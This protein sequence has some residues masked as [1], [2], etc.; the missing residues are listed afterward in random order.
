[1]YWGFYIM[2]NSVKKI[3]A[4]D[5][6]KLFND[7]KACILDV[8]E[9]DEHHREHIQGSELNPLS[10]L[11]LQLKDTKQYLISCQSGM[12][13]AQAANKFAEANPNC[14]IQIIDGGIVEWKKQ[15]LPVNRVAG[16]TISIMRQVQII[17]GSMVTAGVILGNLYDPNFYYLSAFVGIGLIFSGA[18]GTCMMGNILGKLSFNKV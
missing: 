10:A 1:M 17:A 9:A 11:N 6:S 2:S 18:S 13:A 4:K 12:R 14:N 7:G 8:R 16:S 15:G 3:L 5:A